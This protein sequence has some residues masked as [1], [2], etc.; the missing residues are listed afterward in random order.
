MK[1]KSYSKL[2]TMFFTAVAVTLL[3]EP[4]TYLVSPNESLVTESGWKS[5]DSPRTARIEFLLWYGADINYASEEHRYH[6]PL[7]ESIIWDNREVADLLI[8][9]GAK[10]EL[11]VMKQTFNG[12]LMD[13]ACIY[14]SSNSIELLSSLGLKVTR[15]HKD[16]AK[17]KTQ[18]DKCQPDL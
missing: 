16:S 6:T 12:N 2:L 10:L 8:K 7:I 3:N 11:G 4:I 15:E 13:I 14:N 18:N 9:N 5:Y 1:K 17:S